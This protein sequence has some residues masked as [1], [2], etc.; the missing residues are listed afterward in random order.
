VLSLSTDHAEN[1]QWC[2]DLLLLPFQGGLAHLLVIISPLY[3]IMFCTNK[4]LDRK[5]TQIRL[6]NLYMGGCTCIFP[7]VHVHQFQLIQKTKA[8]TLSLWQFG[9]QIFQVKQP[10]ARNLSLFDITLCL[11]HPVLLMY[12]LLDDPLSLMVMCTPLVCIQ[13]CS[14]IVQSSLRY[15]SKEHN[16]MYHHYLGSNHPDDK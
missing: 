8:V 14:Q 6:F 12:L 15:I 9:Y 10:I 1:L 16:T 3:H 7:K 11:Q 5:F 4:I 13:T 2:N